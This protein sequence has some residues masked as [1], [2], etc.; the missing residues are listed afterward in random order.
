MLPLFW[1]DS[2]F[3]GTVFFFYFLAVC[4]TLSCLDRSQA[5]HCDDFSFQEQYHTYQN[6][7]YAVN[8]TGGLVG[9]A[10]SATERGGMLFSVAAFAD[11]RADD[12]MRFLTRP[13]SL[14][15]TV[16]T[17]VNKA[18]KRDDRKRK[19]HAGDPADVCGL[20]SCARVWPCVSRLFALAGRDAVGLPTRL[21]LGRHSDTTPS[22]CL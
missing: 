8:S 7:G 1:L 15:D 10:K 9:S 21:G 4:V 14:G 5:E 6:F 20:G 3:N 19:L 16:F 18:I 2:C 11:V 17:A 13:P 22:P 12:F